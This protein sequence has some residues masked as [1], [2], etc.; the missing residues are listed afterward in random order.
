MV[1]EIIL[2]AGGKMKEFFSMT[3]ED[4]EKYIMSICSDKCRLSGKTAA[5][6]KRVAS[7]QKNTKSN[8]EKLVIVEG[9]WASG[10]ALKYEISI[11]TLIICAQ[12]ITSNE[13]YKLMMDLI[14]RANEVHLVSES[15]F[16][17]ISEVGTS[18]GLIALAKFPQK[19]LDYLSGRKNQ[20]V[21]VLDGLEI[22]GNIGTIIRSCDG[23]ET[24]AV[25]IC[26][27]KTR[28]THPKM[29]RSSQGSCLKVPV[30]ET[31]VDELIEFLKANDYRIIL[32]DTDADNYYF[33][34]SYSGNVALVMGSERYGISKEWYETQV[35]KVMI[36]MW[37]DCDSLNVGIAATIL[38]YEAAIKRKGMLKGNKP[39]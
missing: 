24:D 13:A 15:T 30:I 38:L 9:I 19:T 23:T 14:R 21:A 34:E 26:N 36:P 3:T 1:L 32:A 8:P 33:D 18:A 35:S 10:L 11:S 27:K 25:I 31:E 28:V 29:L 22:P 2:K 6:M 16:K 12:D 7:I 4:R 5:V 39:R 17:K 20:I 37:G